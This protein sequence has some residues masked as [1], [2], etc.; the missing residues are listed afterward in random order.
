MNKNIYE[1]YWETVGEILEEGQSETNSDKPR[2]KYARKST[3][4][5]LSQ[6]P[7]HSLDG[8]T[9][10]TRLYQALDCEGWKTDAPCGKNW[11]WRTKAPNAE[12]KSD[13]NLEVKLERTIVHKGRQKQQDWTWQM[14]TA[15][16]VQKDL[17]AEHNA[18]NKRTSIDLVRKNAN[19]DYAFVE[20]KVGSDNPLYALFE[21]LGYALAY[22]HA[23]NEGSHSQS[24]PDHDVMTADRIKLV[25]LGP[26]SWYQYKIRAR[27]GEAKAIDLSWLAKKIVDGLQALDLDKRPREMAIKLDKYPFNNA[28]DIPT[29]AEFIVDAAA[30]W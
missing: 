26:E 24:N 6:V 29:A 25:V 22:L 5:D 16:G 1:R 9:L 23:R 17:D 14:S 12:E 11:V 21:L 7:R 15:S 10:V 13:S 30:V 8:N 27:Q 19:N 28:S 20:L 3:A 2:P 18:K 4:I